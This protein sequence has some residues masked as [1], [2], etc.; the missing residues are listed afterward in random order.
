MLSD[1]FGMLISMTQ[2]NAKNEPLFRERRAVVRG[3]FTLLGGAVLMFGVW[4]LLGAIGGVGGQLTVI[5]LFLTAVQMAVAVF[6]AYAILRRCDAV[7]AIIFF[8]LLEIVTVIFV[9]SIAGSDAWH[10]LGLLFGIPLVLALLG[11]EQ[12]F[13]RGGPVLPELKS[14][15]PMYRHRAF[16]MI[17]LASTVLMLSLAFLTKGPPFT[18]LHS[19]T[20][21]FSGNSDLQAVKKVIAR[22]IDVNAPDPGL[23]RT[24]LHFAA[25]HDSVEL[26]QILLDAGADVNASNNWGD[27]P[28]HIAAA[29]I[30]SP[31]VVLK[32]IEAGADVNA[33][34]SLGYTPLHSTAGSFV[35][36]FTS[37]CPN[38]L[39]ILQALI[40]AGADVNARSWDGETPLHEAAFHAEDPLIIVA[41]VEAGAEIEA[42]S[43]TVKDTPLLKAARYGEPKIVRA[44][45]S[46]GADVNARNGSRETPLHAAAGRHYYKGGV[47]SKRLGKDVSI[48]NSLVTA[49]A[50]VNAR[51]SEGRTPLDVAVEGYDSPNVPNVLRSAGAVSGTQNSSSQ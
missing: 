19:L 30:K 25:R 9:Y 27:T 10:V 42:R 24:A 49:G 28:L 21:G 26:I 48:I 8:F 39:E 36:S 44:L 40:A 17:L 2:Q 7:S 35:P 43:E 15:K 11:L 23:G 22:G 46:A 18:K 12:L 4:F 6:L 38:Q 50:D 5:A 31:S 33:K 32:L 1:N 16:K 47:A 51:D 3:V 45:I 37:C 29:E 34:S 20:L 41:L 13:R 14:D